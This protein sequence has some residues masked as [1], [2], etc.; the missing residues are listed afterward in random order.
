MQLAPC[1]RANK[2]CFLKIMY[3]DNRDEKPLPQV[4]LDRRAYAFL[5]DFVLVWIMSS[6]VNNSFLRFLLFMLCWFMLRVIVVDKNYGQ[7]LGRWALDMKI[8]DGRFYRRIPPLVS[9]A[10]REGILGFTAFLAMVGL[11]SFNL[12][13]LISLVTPLLVDCGIALGDDQYS[14]TLHDRL[15]NTMIIESRR[16]FSLDLRL[17]QWTR[18]IKHTIRQNRNRRR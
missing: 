9:L 12:L 1:I 5:I 4:P 10:K 6:L 13:W 16:G 8:I 7:S 17:R 2:N 15:A 3:I 11:N 18:E 14:Q